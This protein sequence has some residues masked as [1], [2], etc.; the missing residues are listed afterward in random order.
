MYSC[1]RGSRSRRLDIYPER[2]NSLYKLNAHC[3]ESGQPCAPCIPQPSL[4][5]GLIID[6]NRLK[7]NS[8]AFL[9][10]P[11]C[12]WL[13][14]LLFN[15]L[16]G[17]RKL[18]TWSDSCREGHWGRVFDRKRGVALDQCIH[19]RSTDWSLAWLSCYGQSISVIWLAHLKYK[20]SKTKSI[21]L[22]DCA[23]ASNYSP[24]VHLRAWTAEPSR[25]TSRPS[26]T[27]MLPH[28]MCCNATLPLSPTGKLG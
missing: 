2:G 4:F 17:L 5:A 21:L 25:V 27:A 1:S 16:D 20:Q 7:L 6:A 3:R 24:W 18:N 10:A 19:C 28:A 12:N 14:A 13:P 11:F 15:D 26:T 22:I 9:L 23:L 8:W